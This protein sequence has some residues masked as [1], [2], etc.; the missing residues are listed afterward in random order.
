MPTEACNLLSNEKLSD[1][2]LNSKLFFLIIELF[3]LKLLLESS[4]T[5]TS[6]ERRFQFLSSIHVRHNQEIIN[7]LSFHKDS[8]YFPK[9]P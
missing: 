9:V 7:N 3:S 1:E 5:R 8:V 4:L 6:T 2:I